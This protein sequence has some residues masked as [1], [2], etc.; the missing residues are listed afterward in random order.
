MVDWVGEQSSSL[1]QSTR[2]GGGIFRVGE[3]YKIKV[4]GRYYDGKI[5][6]SGKYSCLILLMNLTIY[7]AS[8]I[9]TT[10]MHMHLQEQKKKWKN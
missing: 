6:S 8:M 1:L 10:Y 2:V 9:V 5:V 7:T 3:F 4:A